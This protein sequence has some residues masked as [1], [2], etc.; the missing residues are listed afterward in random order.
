M[1]DLDNGEDK[2]HTFLRTENRDKAEGFH[3]FTRT[4][5]DHSSAAICVVCEPLTL[6]SPEHYRCRG[7][8]NEIDAK[9]HCFTFCLPR[10]SISCVSVLRLIG[11][12]S[13]RN[14]RWDKFAGANQLL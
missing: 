8:V 5:A 1:G 4:C 13:K 10:W 6:E 9:S 12:L 2:A 3:R 11:V 7:V 14:C